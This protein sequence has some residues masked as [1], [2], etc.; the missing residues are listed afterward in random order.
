M[1]NYLALSLFLVACLAVGMLG[2]IATQQSVSTWYE[3]L[4]K[5]AFTPPNWVFGPVWTLLYVL[6]AVAAWLVWKRTGFWG[7]SFALTLFGL[8]LLLNLGWTLTF[9]GMKNPGWAFFE[10]LVLV[11]LIAG[12]IK[13][14]QRIRPAAAYLMWPY[15]AWTSFATLL[16][17]SI[18]RMNV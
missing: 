6:M 8:Q 15:L 3:T 4:N 2:S 10:I 1:R 7:A 18:W 14:F 16:N 17:Y 9:F 5:P 13:A 11:G 12:T